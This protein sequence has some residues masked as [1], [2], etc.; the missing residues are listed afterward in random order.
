M[1]GDRRK[2]LGG[3][4]KHAYVANGGHELT[5]DLIAGVRSDVCFEINELKKVQETD[6]G[7]ILTCESKFVTRKQFYIAS[8]VFGALGIG[9]LVRN[10]QQLID[11]VSKLI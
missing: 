11:I 8:A 3:V 2:P 6:R 1:S 9:L 7:H 4:S 10:W 5:Y